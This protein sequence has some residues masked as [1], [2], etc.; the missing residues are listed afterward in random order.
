MYTEHRL[1]V[2]LYDSRTVCLISTLE[3]THSMYIL[4]MPATLPAE[5]RGNDSAAR[6]RIFEKAVSV[7][8]CDVDYTTRSLCNHIAHLICPIILPTIT[9]ASL[10][11][12]TATPLLSNAPGS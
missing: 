6:L 10:S 5:P 2:V 12:V 3:V 8:P 7:D 11:Q 1:E 9:A 4:A